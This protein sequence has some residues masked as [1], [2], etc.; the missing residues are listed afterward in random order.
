MP[1]ALPPA[2]PEPSLWVL[3]PGE[4][5]VIVGYDDAL[6]AN[7]RVRLMELGFH[8]GESVTCLQAPGLGAPRVYRVS[9]SVFSLDREVAGGI[10]VGGADDRP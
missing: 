5:R 10:L 1:N 6:A 3:P 8:V 2:P 7:Y 9:N 4:T